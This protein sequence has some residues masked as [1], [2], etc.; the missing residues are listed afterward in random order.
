MT[1]IESS[2]AAAVDKLSGRF[3]KDGANILAKTISALCNLSISQGVFPSACK[4]A[5]LKPIFKMGKKT[6]P[7]NYRPISLLPSI[8]KII[9]RV[10]HDQKNAFLSDEDILYTYQSGFRGNHSTNL[11]L[12]FLTDKILKAIDEGLSTGMIL[13]DLQKAFDTIDHEIF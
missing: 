6:D 4:V 8:S 3:L 12:S 9:E 2:K 11:C 13:I 10:I 5:K 7:S 1:N